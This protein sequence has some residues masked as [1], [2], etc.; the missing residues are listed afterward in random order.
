MS[1]NI[2]ATTG[3]GNNSKIG[4]FSV[5][6]FFDIQ[7]LPEMGVVEEV[8]ASAMVAIHQVD[9]FSVRDLWSIRGMPHDPSGRGSSEDNF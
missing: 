6:Y 1:V 5:S 7:N 9:V 2:D 3:S 4:F 8:A